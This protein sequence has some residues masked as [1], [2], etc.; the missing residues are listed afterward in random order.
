VL[1]VRSVPFFP[2]NEVPWYNSKLI[3][4]DGTTLTGFVWEMGN[5][6]IDAIHQFPYLVP[7]YLQV[8]NDTIFSP[9]SYGKK[10]DLVTQYDPGYVEFSL[11]E[12]TFLV[13]TTSVMLNGDP[14]P[15][16]TRTFR[17]QFT[18]DSWTFLS[19]ENFLRLSI[20]VG[21][22]SSGKN[23]TSIE[24][25]HNETNATA[26]NPSYLITEDSAEWTI[27]LPQNVLDAAAPSGVSASPVTCTFDTKTQ[28]LE[29]YLPYAIN[30]TTGKGATLTYTF[31]VIYDYIPA[32][33]PSTSLE[34]G[35]GPHLLPLWIVLGVGGGIVIIGIIVAIVVA[36]IVWRIIKTKTANYELETQFDKT[37]TALNTDR[38]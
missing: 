22:G 6:Y 35:G 13:N 1:L 29:A 31:F 16:T 14:F 9:A 37:E 33:L 8:V 12:E 19:T 30:A 28:I 17:Y 11:Q 15:V 32:P 10:R 24:A 36:I 2:S 38:L 3:K 34:D 7:P 21:I 27:I 26:G 18:V 20:V 25:T 23:A 5:T 4:P